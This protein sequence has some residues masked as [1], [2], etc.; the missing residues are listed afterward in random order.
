MVPI[1]DERCAAT[2]A[3]ALAHHRERGQETGYDMLKGDH[4]ERNVCNRPES[5]FMEIT[6][7]C[8]CK[9]L[10]TW[11]A[12]DMLLLNAAYNFH[13]VEIDLDIQD[14]VYCHT[15]LGMDVT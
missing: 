3:C 8:V 9:L 11:V 14:T 15:L 6:T 2:L 4:S 12:E 13:H 7:V 10:L 1:A 5:Y